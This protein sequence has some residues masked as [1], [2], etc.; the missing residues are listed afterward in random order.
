M[1][2]HSAAAFDTEALAKT[3]HALRTEQ[4]TAPTASFPIPPD[5]ATAAVAAKRWQA[6]KAQP[7]PPGRRR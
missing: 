2:D 1:S 4:K 3:I 7:A 5:L 6:S